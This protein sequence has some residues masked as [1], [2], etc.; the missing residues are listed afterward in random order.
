MTSRQIQSQFSTFLSHPQHHHTPLGL[1]SRT[2]LTISTESTG[3]RF[4]YPDD[5]CLT[6]Y[7]KALEKGRLLHTQAH[8]DQPSI[9]QSEFQSV[10]D[11]EEWGYVLDIKIDPR[12][13]IMCS[14]QHVLETARNGETYLAT[15][16]WFLNNIYLD[17]GMIESAANYA[18]YALASGLVEFVDQPARATVSTLL[19]KLCHWSDMAYLIW[20][21]VTSKE[22][23][24]PVLRT[25]SHYGDSVASEMVVQ[26]V[27]AGVQPRKSG[28]YLEYEF[29][30]DSDEGL[31]ILGTPEAAGTAYLLVQHREGL[32]RRVVD[33]IVASQF[34]DPDSR[35]LQIV[36][37]IKEAEK[38]DGHVM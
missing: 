17:D 33:K 10:S 25:V 35:H 18:P 34:A 8:S 11:L 1:C 16:A 7:T 23:P 2:K 9:P 14:A 21:H 36:F 37:H 5:E 20:L 31:A 26:H 29:D 38:V 15:D 19:P 27:T 13:G 4:K 12:V 30:A 28:P 32:G 24:K 3:E 6:A 22:S